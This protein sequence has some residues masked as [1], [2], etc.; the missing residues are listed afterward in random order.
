ML[1]DAAGL[2]GRDIGGAQRVEQRGL[3]VVDM[4]HDGHH[5]RA[6]D[7]V[8]RLIG[9]A[10]NALFDIVLGDTADPVAELLHD[11]FGSVG[12]DAF[13]D[14]GHDAHF[15][16][17]L[18]HVGA[19]R[20]HAV[21]EFADGDGLGQDDVSHDLQPIRAEQ[22]ELLLAAFAFTLAAHRGKR[23]NAL[24]L[25]LDRGLHVDAAATATVVDAFLRRGDGGL[26][27]RQHWAARAADAAGFI[28]LLAGASAQPEGFGG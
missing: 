26:A 24:V 27:G 4:A 12:V 16:Q 13:A 10:A 5:R 8:V 15:H 25:A 9:V 6:G 1:G 17:R 2:A 7:H 23:A 22:F 19:A 20:G 18:D 28:F 14:R 11:Q 21:G 3:A